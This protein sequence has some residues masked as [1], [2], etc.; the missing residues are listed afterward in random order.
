MYLLARIKHDPGGQTTRKNILS[1]HPI[2][3]QGIIRNLRPAGVL[4]DVPCCHGLII[5]QL[6]HAPPTIFERVLK[7]DGSTFRSSESWVREFL[8]EKL[9]WRMRSAIRAAQKLPANVDEVCQEQIPSTCLN[10]S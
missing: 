8:W 7:K 10:S 9:N 6:Y 2:V 3:T 4:L 1:E 5:G